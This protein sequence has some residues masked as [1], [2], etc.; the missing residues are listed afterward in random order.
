MNWQDEGYLIN[1]NKY[2]E[3]SSI[4]E[5][6]TNRYGKKT[7]I[8]FGS[9]SQKIKSYLFIGNKFHINYSSKNEN[10]VGSFKIEIN[11]VNTPI[12]L[13]DK[14]K[15]YCIIYSVNL[16]KILSVENQK[17]EKIFNLINSFFKNLKYDFDFKNYIFWELE[18]LKNFGYELNF[19]D[20]AS[21]I[22]KNGRTF[23]VLK[24]DQ[25]IKIPE[26]LINK[27]TN[28]IIEY[29]DLCSGFELTGDFINKSVLNESNIPI[30]PTRNLL[31]KF[32]KLFTNT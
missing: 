30:P 4:A 16:I 25:N 31:L 8:I 19:S 17:N 29:N 22:N 21:Q 5:F 26:F 27:N 6:F 12:Y 2:N 28:K 11:S 7:G 23:Y 1:I 13:D 3:N 20:Y 9:T 18:I 10:S 32:F 15:L 14:L 24:N